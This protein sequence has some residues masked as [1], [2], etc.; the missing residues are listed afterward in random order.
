MANLQNTTL[1]DT[2]FLKLPVG[3]TGTRPTASTG[4]MRFNSDTGLVEFYNATLTSWIN[5]PS[6]GIIASGGNTTYDMDVDGTTYRVHVFTSTGSSTFS[7][8]RG[9]EVEY[10]IVAGG[11]GGSGNYYDDGAGGGGGGLITGTTTVTPQD[12][13]ITVG[14]GQGRTSGGGTGGNS[15]AFGLTANGGGGGAG[16]RGA[17]AAGGSGGGG[18]GWYGGAI[19]GRDYSG[20][21]ATQP[22]SASGGYG[23]AGGGIPGGS[24]L[25]STYPYS[26]GGGGA[27]GPGLKPE[28]GGGGNSG[29]GGRGLA[30]DIG[31]YFVYYAG[32]GGGV[33]SKPGGWGGGATASYGRGGTAAE[34]GVP[35][36]GGGGG[37][38]RNYT[39][40]T[41]LPSGGG[42][43]IVIV[44]YP[45]RQENPT[46]S[47]GRVLSDGMILNLDM[48]NPAVWDGS[49]S[50]I[51]DGNGHG[52]DGWIG[53]SVTPRYPR[54]HR[55]AFQWPHASTDS[56]AAQIEFAHRK[57]FNYNYQNWCYI[58]WLRQLND[59]NGGW[60]QFFIK[61]NDGG[62][63]RPGVWFYSGATSRFHLTWRASGQSQQS[64]DTASDFL[65]PINTWYHITIQSRN[66]IMGAWRN[67]IADGNTITIADR[68]FNTQPLHIGYR[69]DYR[70]LGMEIGS[71]RVFNRSFTDAEIQS[72]YEAT[73]WRY[74]V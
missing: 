57:E 44:R 68:N 67:G 11:G 45:L 51:R 60:A 71:F 54:T 42:S 50:V 9:G 33:R 40:E 32:G 48:A 20:G 18:G 13:T 26:G 34:E 29:E 28:P 10:L 74:G 65:D 55:S 64:V 14:A 43:G 3:A 19:P 24:T 47:D 69:G 23:H 35:N 66:S 1:S 22:G 53:T 12:Y 52:P 31:G 61:G 62:N 59:D 15:A 6:E 8:S 7:V 36:T 37:G 25:S 38:G 16:H 49:S 39:G 27:G 2:G 21:A 30:V 56:A 4:Q 46:G 5:A 63:R 41:G 72:D 70:S 17:G 73:R 58:I